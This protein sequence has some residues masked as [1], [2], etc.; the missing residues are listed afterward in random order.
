MRTRLLILATSI[1]LLVLAL[2]VVLWLRGLTTSYYAWWRF[3][4]KN[5][6]DVRTFSLLAGRGGFQ[7]EYFRIACLSPSEFGLGKSDHWPHLRKC[8]QQDSLPSW[9]QPQRDDDILGYPFGWP[10]VGERS[11]LAHPRTEIYADHQINAHMAQTWRGLVLPYWAPGLASLA[12]CSLWPGMAVRRHMRHQH[13]ARSGL[14]QICGYDLRG[15]RDRCSECGTSI[16]RETFSSSN[17]LQI[18][19]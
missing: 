6:Q 18:P 9:T 2:I 7:F 15:S 11:I 14:C 5:D 10:E 8:E 16:T 1:S 12:I 4:T 3:G 19:P 13:R 17:L